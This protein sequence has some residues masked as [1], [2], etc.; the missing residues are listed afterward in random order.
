M[1]YVRELCEQERTEAYE[2]ELLYRLHAARDGTL[3]V[4]AEQMVAAAA[5]IMRTYPTARPTVADAAALARARIGDL[6]ARQLNEINRER[7]DKAVAAQ[8][9]REYWRVRDALALAWLS[10][11]DPL[12]C[13]E[14]RDGEIVDTLEEVVREVDLHAHLAAVQIVYSGGEEE[15]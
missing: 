5:E 1:T 2:R 11:I 4:D 13:K 6:A 8:T 14:V 12:S 7:V 3:Y 10:R 9:K 15:A